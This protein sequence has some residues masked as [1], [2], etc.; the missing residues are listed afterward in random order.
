M[1]AVGVLQ[2]MLG[3]DETA[4]TLMIATYI[5]I[6]SFGT[7]TDITGDGA[8]AVVMEQLIGDRGAPG[9]P[10]T[11]DLEVADGSSRGESRGT[12][13]TMTTKAPTGWSGPS[14]SSLTM[15][16]VQPQL[17]TLQ[18]SSVTMS[19]GSSPGRGSVT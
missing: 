9:R 11:D 3:F 5:A 2:G 1:A 10:V 13:S 17:D 12:D 18:Y 15:H 16:R 6:D 4:V 14:S 8:I 19:A 7:A